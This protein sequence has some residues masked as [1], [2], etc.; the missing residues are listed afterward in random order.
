MSRLEA[1]GQ[2][3]PH[4]VA[5][6]DAMLSLSLSLSLSF[7]SVTGTG[8]TLAF[9]LPAIE[10]A[11]PNDYGVKVLVVAP[12][13]ELARQVAEE[14]QELLVYHKVRRGGGCKLLAHA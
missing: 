6:T 7:Y 13:R 4:L 10:R 2:P 14:A 5:L 3:Q 1:A 9:L 8:K 12:A 11:V